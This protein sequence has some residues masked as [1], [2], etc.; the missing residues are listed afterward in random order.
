MRVTGRSE[1]ERLRVLLAEWDGTA[2]DRRP[3]LFGLGGERG[4]LEAN[5]ADVP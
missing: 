2:P 1:D 4:L 5:G 3:D